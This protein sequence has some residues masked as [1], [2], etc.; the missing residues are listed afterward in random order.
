MAYIGHSGMR[1]GL[2][3]AISGRARV[4][5][6]VSAIS[7][8]REA[9]HM[10][11]VARAPRTFRA[12]VP[13]EPLRSQKFAGQKLFHKLVE[14]KSANRPAPTGNSFSGDRP[15]MTTLPKGH[16]IRIVVAGSPP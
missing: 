1:N 5:K 14:E 4:R 8:G 15:S 3:A 2:S 7:L 6:A 9:V 12:R 13:R 16:A 10:L 11:R